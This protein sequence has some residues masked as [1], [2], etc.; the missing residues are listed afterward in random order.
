MEV[1]ENQYHGRK[2]LD[3]CVLTGVRMDL[4]PINVTVTNFPLSFSTGWPLD[5][6]P[7]SKPT[8]AGH[9]GRLQG[10]RRHYVGQNKKGK[11][12]SW[13]EFWPCVFP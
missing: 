1:S 3:Y 4:W 2:K 8:S 9:S 7:S 11:G 5:L 12:F 6:P 10:V 13:K